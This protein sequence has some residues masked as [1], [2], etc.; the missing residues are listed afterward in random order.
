MSGV[1]DELVAFLVNHQGADAVVHVRVREDPME[2]VTQMPTL[3]PE[4]PKRPPVPN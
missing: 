2:V 1:G 3:E 4:E